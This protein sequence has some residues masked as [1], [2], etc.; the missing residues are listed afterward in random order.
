MIKIQVPAT[1]ANFGPGFD[2]LGASLGL[3]NYIEMGFSDEPI[4]EVRGEGKEEIPTDETNLVYQAGLKVLELAGVDK[5]L[6]IVLENNIPIARGL[7]SSAACIVGGLKAANR[8]VGDAFDN[9]ELIRIA[10]QMEGHPDNVVPAT[11]GGFCLSMIHE[12]RIIYKTFPMPF[13][14]QFVVCIPEFELKTEDARKI[15][16]K[17]IKFQDA[18]FNI[19]RVAMLVAAMARGDFTDMDIFCQDRLHQPYRSRLIPGMD[20]ILATVRSKGAYAGFLSGSGPSVVCL[21]LRERSDALGEHMVEIFSKNGI[22]S[23][24]KVLSPDSTGARFL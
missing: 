9:I 23:S 8:L 19:G 10:T 24:Y 13:W 15:L 7:G 5:H 17:E 22:K 14:L 6:K 1:T 2:C 11:F 12:G 20:E 3:Y 21:S 16:P 4:V 18:V